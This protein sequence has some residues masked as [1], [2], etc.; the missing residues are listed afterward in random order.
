MKDDC[1]ASGSIVC[2]YDLWVHP[3]GLGGIHGLA[4][5]LPCGTGSAAARDEIAWNRGILN[6]PEA[7]GACLMLFQ[8]KKYRFTDRRKTNPPF[9]VQE[10][11]CNSP[12]S[13]P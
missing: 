7:V 2:H 6:D 5:S 10:A 13:G 9:P 4:S 3:R 8:E 1:A 12:F 11:P